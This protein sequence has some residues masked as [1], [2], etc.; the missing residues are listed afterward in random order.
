MI[1]WVTDIRKKPFLD[2]REYDFSRVNG[3]S[4]SGNLSSSGAGKVIT[5]AADM[6]FGLAA[7]NYAYL[8]GG[9]GTA[10]AVLITAVSGAAGGAGTATVT[11]ANT[12]TGAWR[13]RSATAGIQEAA[14]LAAAPGLEVFI[15]AGSYTIY[16]QILVPHQYTVWFQGAG[17]SATVLNVASTFSLSHSGVFVF[18]PSQPTAT[19]A[20]AGGVCGLTIGFE[21]PDSTNLA[22]YTHWPPAVYTSG[23]NHVALEYAIIERA[24]DGFTAPN[25][26]GVTLNNVGM[27]FFHRGI[28]VD[29]A[30]DTVAI[31]H[32]EGWVFGLTANQSTAFRA[33]ATNNYALDC[34]GC[35]LV[36]IN[37]FSTD[38]GKSFKFYKNGSGVV[39]HVE[40][41]NV[42]ID[43]NGGFEMSNGFVKIANIT[44]SIITG[45]A[46]FSISG[47]TLKMWG[48]TIQNNGSTTAAITYNPSQANAGFAAAEAPGVFIYGLDIGETAEDQ[49][50]IYAT[51]TTPFTGVG[52]VQVIGGTV[53]RA[54]ASYL[55]PLFQEVAGTGTVVMNI[56]HVKISNNGATASPAF[57]F[58]S[59][60]KHSV[61]DCDGPGGWT[62][63]I[64]S[65]TRWFNNTGFTS[66][67][68]VLPAGGLQV[69]GLQVFANN[70]AAI[71]GGLAVGQFYRT[72]GDPDPVCV[73]H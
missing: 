26:N 19:A 47:G 8:S 17:R 16:A 72:G 57:S 42:H 68:N 73:V 39:P 66:N 36:Q 51:S 43:A 9:T 52:Y 7:S 69:I 38:S 41:V 5:F 4:C 25:S 53:T 20:D 46:A 62:F 45:A 56:A 59:S 32:F 1:N 50:V 29:E 37:G 15:P 2:P 54:P 22:L 70:A 34:S 10:E 31:N 24:W 48:V 49:Q 6:P 18:S 65:T 11:T 61:I 27:S 13:F 23:T 21:Q 71:G 30:F 44:A 3:A 58:G 28:T 63:T 40:A 33:I 64:P 14:Q 12:H 60:N 35:D 67:V 55:L